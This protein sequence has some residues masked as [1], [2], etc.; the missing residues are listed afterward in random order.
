MPDYH[1]E[2]NETFDAL[3]GGLNEVD[4]GRQKAVEM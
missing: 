3:T 4:G 1:D 2:R